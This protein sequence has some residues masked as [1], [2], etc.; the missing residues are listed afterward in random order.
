MDTAPLPAVPADAAGPPPEGMSGA[1]R[2]L[3][4]LAGLASA[5][6]VVIGL[7]LVVVQLIA[8]EL[9]PGSGM[10]AAAGPT[11][12]RALAQVGVGALGEFSVWARPRMGRAARVWSAVAVLVATGVVLWLSWWR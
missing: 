6:L 4:I 1:G 7:G 11:W 9:A 5:G 10:S 2:F 12:W 8:P 3:E